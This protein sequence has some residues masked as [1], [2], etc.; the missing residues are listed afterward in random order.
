MVICL[1]KGANE[2]HTVQLMPLLSLNL[3]LCYN[4]AKEAIEWDFVGG[5][6]RQLINAI[7]CNY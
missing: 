4:P 3:L 6:S 5:V 7:I 1:K 2:L